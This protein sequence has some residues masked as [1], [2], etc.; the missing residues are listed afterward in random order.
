M[1][2]VGAGIPAVEAAGGQQVLVEP[3]EGRI[4]ARRVASGRE[5]GQEQERGPEEV[6]ENEQD[7]DEA[8]DVGDPPPS[9]GRIDIRR[10]L[11]A[12]RP[13]AVPRGSA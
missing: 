2:E 13:R 1:P 7:R 5:G 9:G 6:E 10:S 4:V 3:D 8:D 11:A 12:L